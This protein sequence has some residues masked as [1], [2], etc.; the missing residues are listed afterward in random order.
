M[1]ETQAG[2]EVRAGRLTRIRQALSPGEWAR[3]GGMTTAVVG[4]NVVG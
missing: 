1:A 3:V 4:L 2:L